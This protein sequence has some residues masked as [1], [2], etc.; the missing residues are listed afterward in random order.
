MEKNMENAMEAELTKGLCMHP[1]IQSLKPQTPKR[2][3]NNTNPW[4]LKSVQGYLDPEGRLNLL[5]S[6]TSKRIKQKRTWKMEW[7]PE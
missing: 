6:R 1:G 7:E 4:A 3:A 2:Y 5:N